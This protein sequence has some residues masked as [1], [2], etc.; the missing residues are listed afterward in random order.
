MSIY[1]VPAW[2][3]IQAWHEYQS[4]VT[5]RTFGSRFGN[6][7]DFTSAFTDAAANF[8]TGSANLAAKAALKRIQDATA[9]KQAASARTNGVNLTI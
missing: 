1:Q 5:Q 8:Y 3:Q 2:K 7:T 9:A 6:Q 4:Y